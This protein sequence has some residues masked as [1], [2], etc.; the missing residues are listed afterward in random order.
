MQKLFKKKTKTREE[1]LAACQAM[2][3]SK[4]R[5]PNS[6]SYPVTMIKPQVFDSSDPIA[7]AKHFDEE[8]YVV[9]Q[10]VSDQQ[11]RT[12]LVKFIKSINAPEAKRLGFLDVCH[13][14]TLAQMRQNP[15]LYRVFADLLEDDELWV[16]FDRVIYQKPNDRDDHLIPHVDQ[17]PIGEFFGLQGLIALRDMNAS[18]GTLALIPKSKEFFQRYAKWATSGSYVEYQDD[19]LPMFIA[20]DLQEGDLVIWDSRTTTSRYCDYYREM[21]QLA[22]LI[23]FMPVGNEYSRLLRVQAFKDG[24]GLNWQSAGL[25]ASGYNTSLR[26]TNEQLTVLGTK[27]YGLVNWKESPTSDVVVIFLFACLVIAIM[28]APNCLYYFFELCKS[29]KW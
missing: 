12:N 7:I 20:L 27:L 29:I 23:S 14:D 10:N 17:N 13:D 3:Q 22:M 8:G 4:I 25:R 2:F 26:N 21:D 19:D 15:R 18:T 6:K 24:T 5:P 1:I 16:V 28:M 11:D 9:V